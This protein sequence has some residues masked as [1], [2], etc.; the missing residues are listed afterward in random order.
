MKNIARMSFEFQN[1]S[2]LQLDTV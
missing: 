1:Y 2:S